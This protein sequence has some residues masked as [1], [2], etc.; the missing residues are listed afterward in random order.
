MWQL[1]LLYFESRKI[2]GSCN[3]SD[4][5]QSAYHSRSSGSVP[6]EVFISCWWRKLH[7]RGYFTSRTSLVFCCW[8][9]PH[10]CFSLQHHHSPWQSYFTAAPL[11]FT[12]APRRMWQTAPTSTFL[13]PWSILNVHFRLCIWMTWADIQHTTSKQPCWQ[14]LIKY[15]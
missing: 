5:F 3:G 15:T 11:S 12:I 2:H 6:G 4:D 8:S 10:H 13:Q 1:V 14:M 9:S 7:Q